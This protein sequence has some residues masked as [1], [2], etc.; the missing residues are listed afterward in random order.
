MTNN[1]NHVI[2]LVQAKF[3]SLENVRS[4][5]LNVSLA[6]QS[7][8]LRQHNILALVEHQLSTSFALFLLTSEL[9]EPRV[10]S[11]LAICRAFPIDK[12]F[13]CDTDIIPNNEQT[14]LFNVHYHDIKTCFLI[15]IGA[16]SSIFASEVIRATELS[17]NKAN[18]AWTEQYNWN[19]SYLLSTLGKV[20]ANMENDSATFYD[21]SDSQS[22]SSGMSSNRDSRLKYELTLK[23]N[24]YTQEHIFTVFV[25]TWN[26]NGQLPSTFLHPWLCCDEDP[27]DIYAIGL[28]EVDLSKEA[29]LFNDS[30][31]EHLWH[32]AVTKATHP[33]AKYRRVAVIRLVGIQLMVFINTTHYTHLK[34]IE[35]D[36]VGTGILGKMGNKGGVAVRFELHNKWLCFVNCHLAA[37]MDEVERRNQDY[38]EINSRVSFR[39]QPQSIRDHDYVYWFGDMNYR[40]NELN[41]SQV[42]TYLFRGDL[43]TLLIKDQ[44]NQQKDLNRVLKDYVEGPITFPPTYKYD[45]HSDTFDTSEKA[46]A[47]AWTDRIFY[48]YTNAIVQTTYRSCMQLQISDHK[49][50]SATYATPIGVVDPEKYRKVHETLLKEL[51]KLENEYLPQVTVDQTEVSF[52]LVKFREQPTKEIIIANTGLVPARFEFIKKLNDKTYCKDW[53]TI[54]PFSGCIK[55]GEKCDVQLE[56]NLK[57][58]EGGKLEDILVLHLDNGKD[59]FITVTGECQRTC[60]LMSMQVLVR[61]PL[62]VLRLS[63]Q[64]I[65]HAE[66]LQAPVLYSIPRELWLLVDSLYR[67]GRKTVALFHTSALRDEIIHIRDWLDLGSLESIPGSVY[68]TAEALLLFLSFTSEPIIPLHMHEKCLAASNFEASKQLILQLSDLNRNVFIYVCMFL[69][70]LLKNTEQNG[71]DSNTVA[72]LFGNILLREP[73]R[74]SKNNNTSRGKA[75]FIY[76]FLMN[77]ISTIANGSNVNTSTYQ[78]S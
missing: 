39:K 32:E 49:P 2:N 3:S 33:K 10:F 65:S 59:M 30:Q 9:K 4:I 38:N 27:P 64:Q 67:N 17:G 74:Q 78:L 62:P 58:A 40:I 66:C 68:A 69:Q 48:R 75:K 19:K 77:D 23:E 76:Y 73:M 41:S 42:K 70:E 1:H 44:L 36:H 31:R 24:E 16:E 35:V 5:H 46:R 47:P 51:D 28:Q 7:E 25:G 71:L 26:V 56:I 72:T 60:F 57:C 61:C 54:K 18:F 8:G 13:S 43:Q 63:S 50:V 20:S 15:E 11:D 12:H 6:G 29:F 45:L 52:G 22:E 14:L 53:L 21:F 37:F 55:P 34:N